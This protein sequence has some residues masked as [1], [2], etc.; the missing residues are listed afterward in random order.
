MRT[1][2]RGMLRLALAAGLASQPAGA[3][4]LGPLSHSGTTMNERKGFYLTL[5]NPYPTQ[6]RFRLYS[7]EWASETP[8]SRVLI[9]F[10]TPTLAPRSQRRVLIVA[11]GLVPGEEHKF[12]ICAERVGAPEE[13]MVHAR[14]C[15]KLTARRLV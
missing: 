7:R 12:R 8:A 13:A 1:I 10:P 15:S 11:T 4:G 14:I 9:T 2:A 3:V 6:A 5:I